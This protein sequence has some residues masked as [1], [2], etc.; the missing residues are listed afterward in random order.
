MRDTG[1]SRGVPE[2][3]KTHWVAHGRDNREGLGSVGSPSHVPERS[4]RLNLG[5]INGKC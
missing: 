4:R 1:F 2:R 3:W 5:E